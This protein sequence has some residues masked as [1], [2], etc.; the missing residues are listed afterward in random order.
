MARS[1]ITGGNEIHDWPAFFLL[2]GPM[3]FS[4]WTVLWP[5]G[6]DPLY[7]ATATTSPLD[8]LQ[9]VS[10]RKKQRGR[11][12]RKGDRDDDFWSINM[13]QALNGDIHAYR[14]LLE[15]IALYARAIAK[16][17]FLRANMRGVD[18]DDIV[19][20][21]LLAFHRTRHCWDSQRKLKPW[22]GTIAHHKS[23]DE[24]RRIRSRQMLDTSYWEVGSKETVPDHAPSLVVG[25]LIE[26]LAPRQR[27]IVVSISIEGRSIGETAKRLAMTEGAVRVALHRSL[28][29]MAAFTQ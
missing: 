6:A 11:W 9:L 21:T 4:E 1:S 2:P 13:C 14:Q 24:L 23:I 26:K 17:T 22:I 29:K 18:L 15:E 3:F 19:Q 12:F 27:D 25:A 5:I 20:E 16:Q 8:A 7:D 10:Q 28:K